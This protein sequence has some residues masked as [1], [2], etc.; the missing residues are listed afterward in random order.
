MKHSLFIS[1][2]LTVCLLQVSSVA[3]TQVDN[4]TTVYDRHTQH[5][6]YRTLVNVELAK[7][8]A[9][10]EI[11]AKVSAWKPTIA[12]GALGLSVT[13]IGLLLPIYLE[14]FRNCGESAF[15]LFLFRNSYAGKNLFLMLADTGNTLCKLGLAVVAAPWVAAGINRLLDGACE[16][17]EQ[18]ERNAVSI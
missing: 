10:Q 8:R 2:V 15:S 11:F 16:S 4:S 18:T 5:E 14:F 3:A 9:L 13:T 7:V 6:K 17:L 1:S 12:A